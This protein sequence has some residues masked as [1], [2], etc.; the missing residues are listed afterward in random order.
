MDNAKTTIDTGSQISALGTK[1]ASS[2][3]VEATLVKSY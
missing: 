3:C 2:G 1:I